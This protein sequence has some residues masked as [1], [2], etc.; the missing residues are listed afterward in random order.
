MVDIEQA[1]EEHAADE[2]KAE[3]LRRVERYKRSPSMAALIH[4]LEKYCGGAWPVEVYAG[5]L[6]KEGKLRVTDGVFY[7]PQKWD[8]LADLG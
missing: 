1:R 5:Q 8:D 2:C 3:I 6:V 4:R 7:L